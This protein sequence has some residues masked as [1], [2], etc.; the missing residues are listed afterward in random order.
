MLGVI[1]KQTGPVS[2]LVKLSDGQV[3]RRHQD[4]MRKCSLSVNIEPCIPDTDITVD[5]PSVEESPCTH[6]PNSSES[7]SDSVSVPVTVETDSNTSV[8][9]SPTSSG[10]TYPKRVHKPPVRFEPKL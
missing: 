1:E 8:P 4:Q 3:W 10:K 2:F 5:L 6:T 9:T 7:T